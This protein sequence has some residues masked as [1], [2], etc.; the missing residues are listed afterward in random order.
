MNVRAAAC[1]SNAGSI[2]RTSQLE[3]AR[4]AVVEYIA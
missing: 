1:D 4:N 2:W 3:Y